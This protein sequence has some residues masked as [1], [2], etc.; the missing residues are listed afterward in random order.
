MTSKTMYFGSRERMTW[1][2]C[3]AIDS[4]ISKTK[5]S[6]SGTYLSGGGYVRN[7]TTGH[8]RYQFSWNLANSDDIY[9]ILDYADGLYGNA[10]FYF[11]DP[12]AIEIN[13][14]PQYWA[15]PRLAQQDAPSFDKNALPTL[16]DT[17][18]NTFDYPTKS[19]VYT[20]NVNSVFSSLWIP[21]PSGYTFN[22]GA[23]GSATSTAVVTLTPDGSTTASVTLLP[24][25]TSQR[26]NTTVTGVTGVTVSFSGTG[27]LTL[28]G[29]IAQV[30][31]T[32]DAVPSGSFISGRGHSG[33]EFLG[34]PTLNGY[35]AALDKQGASTT[36]VEI[37]AWL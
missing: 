31:P 16:V 23:H 36:L 19:A 30:R 18:A 24:I 22:F 27:I 12:F 10:P 28:A 21:I 37:G 8:K 34:S 11:L 3:P 26:T 25:T 9:A 29:M 13:V 35:S 5:W 15:S 6:T 33:V 7:S 4:D 17:A 2:K 1:V 20:F 32:G 14:L